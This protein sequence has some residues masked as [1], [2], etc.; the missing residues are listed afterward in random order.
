[1]N[2][3][4]I[5]DLGSQER[6]GYVIGTRL[7]ESDPA[8][9]P[10]L[11]IGFNRQI[12]SWRDEKPHLHRTSEEYFIV[13]EGCLDMLAGN[14]PT[15]INRRELMGIRAGTS[16]QVIGGN[17][18]IENLLIRVPG[19]MEDKVA[20]EPSSSLL[21]DDL[22]VA[23]QSIHIDLQQPHTGYLLGACLPEIHPNHSALLDF[24]CVWGVDPMIEWQHEELHFHSQREEY[25]IVLEGRLDVQLDDSRLSVSAR[26]ILGVR[27][28]TIHRILGGEGP[29]DVIFVRVPGGRG[30]KVTLGPE[31]W[32]A[33]LD[34]SS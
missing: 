3:Y 13:L 23:G 28:G 19:G 4:F 17:A 11:E 33:R 21:E 9:S 26:Q 6:H 27:A 7:E 24:T 20:L 12:N 25:Y 15:K 30:D 14:Q 29:V 2:R 18:P 8:Y 16:H 22:S 10:F 31:H 32:Q 1:M 5:V 34:K